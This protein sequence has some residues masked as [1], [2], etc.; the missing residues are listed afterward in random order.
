MP[1][2][3]QPKPKAR[4]ISELL[5]AQRI[6]KSVPVDVVPTPA[7]SQPFGG[8]SLADPQLESLV[9][10]HRVPKSNGGALTTAE[11]VN[12]LEYLGEE[13]QPVP[14]EPREAAAESTTGPTVI[15]VHLHEALRPAPT[16]PVSAFRFGRVIPPTSREAKPLIAASVASADAAIAESD[17]LLRLP[18][19]ETV[20]HDPRDRLEDDVLQGEI[21]SEDNISDEQEKLDRLIDDDFPFDETQLAAVHGMVTHQFATMVGEAGTGKT[22]VLK[23]LVDLLKTGVASVD[24]SGYW[25]R[26]DPKDD[27]D[28]ERP[29]NLIPSIAMVS[30]TGR[31]SQMVKKNFPRSWHPNIMTIHRMLGFYPE[32]YEDSDV[33]GTIVNKKRFVP[34]YNSANKV[35][36]KI[37]IIDEA[38]MLGLELW[39]QLLAAC[40]SD[41]RIYMIGD[42]RQ[43]PPTHGKSILGFALSKWPVYALTH[44]HRQKGVNNSI[45]DNAHRMMNGVM[46]VC[47]SQ[48]LASEE[49]PKG[50]EF[51]TPEGT[52]KALKWLA[53]NQEWRFLNIRIDENPHKAQQRIRQVMKLLFDK[54][55]LYDPNRDIIIT[56]TNGFEPTAPGYVLGQM[57]LNQGLVS[58]LNAGATRYWIDGGRERPNFALGDKVMATV[59]DYEAGITN[60]MTGIIE[61]INENG[62]YSGNALRFGTVDDVANYLESCDSDEDDDDFDL[63]DMVQGARDALAARGDEKEKRDSGPASHTVVVRFGEGDHSFTVDFSSKSQVASLMLAYAATCHKMQGGEAPLVFVI[64]H[65]TQK[66]PLNREWIYTAGTRASGRCVFLSTRQGMGVAL[67]KKAIEGKTLE[68]KIANFVKLTIP[69][70]IGARVNVKLPEPQLLVELES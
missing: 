5:A 27:D 44:V 59:N 68:D 26:G 51:V 33:Q 34:A 54:T 50:L 60:G 22:T 20:E 55:D 35:P 66:R 69:N 46:P 38:G 61:E 43:L 63:S 21:G 16:V 3:T 10:S 25:Q 13:P 14:S 67:S 48:V 42:I 18:S 15:Q 62:G 52:T 4:S 32:F 49:F 12:R 23:K 36:W 11:P 24:L 17:K 57:P 2:P 53:T 40:P 29:T 6:A 41:T 9:A 1:L 8:K 37:I 28:Y 39:H 47:D 31:A 7:I 19:P 70:A 65:G 45:V 56:P 64:V 58:L 30:F